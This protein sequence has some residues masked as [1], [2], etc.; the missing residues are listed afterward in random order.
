MRRWRGFCKASTRKGSTAIP[1]SPVTAPPVTA[2]VSDGG[3]GG[4][5]AGSMRLKGRDVVDLTQASISYTFSLAAKR[6]EVKRKRRI[7]TEALN[8]G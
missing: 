8:G 5:R 7:E 3:G 4:E 2:A 6:E 1:F